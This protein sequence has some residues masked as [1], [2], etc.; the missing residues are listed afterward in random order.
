MSYNNSDVRVGGRGDLIASYSTYRTKVLPNNLV[1]HRNVLTQ[2]MM[3]TPNT[4]YV[5]KWDYVLNESI[6][7]PKG[8]LIEFDGG[9]IR[10]D[11]GNEFTFTGND[12]IVI[13][14]QDRD[15]VIKDVELL[16]TFIFKGSSD[17]ADEEDITGKTGVLKFADKD[18]D[19]ENF[20]GLGRVYLRKNI[21]APVD[22]DNN[23]WCYKPS[24]DELV[25]L[26]YRYQG[27]YYHIYD[28]GTGKGLVLHNNIV[29]ETDEYNVANL[30]E[31][32]QEHN[33]PYIKN[34][35]RLEVTLPDNTVVDDS[36]INNTEIFYYVYDE[37]ERYAGK[38][39]LTQDMIS[40]PNTIYIIQYN[41]VISPEN[42]NT[43][44]VPE[45][46]VLYFK[47]GSLNSGLL[48]INANTTITNGILNDVLV[49]SESDNIFIEKTKF[50]GGELNA[51]GTAYS[52][53]LLTLSNCQ[54]VELKGCSFRDGR[55]GLYADTCSNIQVLNTEFRNF[56]FWGNYF[57]SGTNLI[58]SRCVCENVNDGIKLTGIIV[59]VLLSDNTCFHNERDGIDF[60]GHLVDKCVIANNF[61]HDNTICGIEFKS[62]NRNEY[63]LSKYDLEESDII[64]KDI[65]IEGN[66]I[67]NNVV[68]INS[69]S[70]YCNTLADRLGRISIC[71]NFISA[72]SA[73]DEHGTRTFGAHL[74]YWCNYSSC[75]IFSNNVL[76][77]QFTEALV[78]SNAKYN[79]VKDNIIYNEKI[80]IRIDNQE[81]SE[82]SASILVT[83]CGNKIH[84]Y[85]SPCINIYEG[86]VAIYVINNY[87]RVGKRSNDNTEIVNN[88]ET[89]VIY[90]NE[91]EDFRRVCTTS[92]MNALNPYLNT[93]NAGFRVFNS[94]YN[95]PAYWNGEGWKDSMGYPADSK[96]KGA[97]NEKPTS[98]T[99]DDEGFVYFAT[100]LN[101]PIY[102]TGE[103]WVDALGES[104]NV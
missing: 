6:T 37:S 43:I 98:L 86:V 15:K 78:L 23:I 19:P 90:G 40:K 56:T 96:H 49:S 29:K 71:N 13:F 94:D 72:A 61:L 11:N 17:I 12:T 95:Y 4:K 84:T 91:S 16:G 14:Y 42:E 35:D 60:A 53:A 31:P 80:G 8:C 57:R 1:D 27:V 33:M 28:E 85:N 82:G 89:C 36:Q 74:C 2:L 5:I 45:G 25:Y 101:K 26:M 20:S 44:E 77:G 18:Y 87:F 66:T 70:Y 64:W 75:L 92:Q 81:Y 102:W 65:S 54:Y 48:R 50:V 83:L 51:A 99:V 76:Q 22:P 59:N 73:V 39:I 104:I 32:A 46:C 62:L 41:Y 9:S 63:P 24:T 3:N 21:G 30:P 7:L 10:N 103:A 38:N 58:V 79:T 93:Y 69:F 97:Y 52:N 68:G 55:L 67:V 88:G 100:D 34:G 47:G